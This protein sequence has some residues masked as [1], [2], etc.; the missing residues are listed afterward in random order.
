MEI[1]VNFKPR[2]ITKVMTAIENISKHNDVLHASIQCAFRSIA[3]SLNY[4]APEAINMW[5]TPLAITLEEIHIAFE[6]DEKIQ[7]LLSCICD[8]FNAKRD[9]LEFL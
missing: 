6:K 3:D 5:W 7:P 9:Y 2:P 4:C 1:P 8:V